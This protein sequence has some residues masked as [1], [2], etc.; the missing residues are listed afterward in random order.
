MV[1]NGENLTGSSWSYL[2]LKPW[3]SE[4]KFTG[5]K[6]GDQISFQEGE[7]LDENP[8]ENG[9]FWGLS[10]GN[11]RHDPE[12]DRLTGELVFQKQNPVASS[13]VGQMGEFL[14]ATVVLSR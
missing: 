1:Q 10:Y 8:A 7:I 4:K 13:G 2:D 14:R 6:N 11:F 12:N 3:F 9:P 5:S